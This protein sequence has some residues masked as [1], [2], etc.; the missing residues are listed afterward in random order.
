[1][2]TCSQQLHQCLDLMARSALLFTD[3]DRANMDILIT[4]LGEVDKQIICAR[5]GLFGT[6]R[7][8]LEATAARYGVPPGAIVEILEKDLR[9]LAVTPEWQMLLSRFPPLVRRR[10]GDG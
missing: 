10:L 5:Y 2:D 3:G 7:Q 6:A 8:P 9:K 1:M 4:M